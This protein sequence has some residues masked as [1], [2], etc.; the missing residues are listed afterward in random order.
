MKSYFTKNSVLSVLLSVALLLTGCSDV[1]GTKESSDVKEVTLLYTN[2]VHAQVE[3]MAATWEDDQPMMGGL[4]YYSSYINKIRAEEKNVAYLDAGDIITG[5]SISTITEGEAAIDLFNYLDV[6]ASVYGNHEF[7]HG[8]ERADS[9]MD[10][11]NFPLLAANVFHKDTGEQFGDPY[12]I[13]DING[14]KVGV[15]GILGK[16]AA[17]DTIFKLIIENLEFREQA[18][19]VQQY[20]DEIEDQVDLIVLLGHQGQ[21]AKQGLKVDSVDVEDKF[22]KDVEVANEVDGI[23]VLISGHAHL[24]IE[25][26]YVADSGTLIVSTRGLGVQVGYLNLEIQDGDIVNHKGH[27]ED[28][29]ADEIEPDPAVQERIDY[30]NQKMADL[31]NEEISYASQQLTRTYEEDSILG[32]LSADAMRAVTGADVAL[33]H[34]GGLRTDVEAGPLTVG[35]AISVL[36]FPNSVYTMT[37]TGEHLLEALEQSAGMNY[38]ILSPSGAE[39][40][41]DLSAEVGSRIVEATVNGKEIDPAAEYVVAL[42]AFVAL[43]GDDFTAFTKG[44]NV[45]S[46]DYTGADALISHLKTLDDTSANVEDRV[47][48]VNN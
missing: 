2:D 40:T 34:P 5:P 8:V 27:L 29:Y 18:P 35:E 33:Q 30:W 1:A 6:D 15:I 25:E 31:T 32:N 19:I 22:A 17:E 12:T 41:I 20:V 26:P 11:A 47:K 13:L 23:D 37:L 3:P 48:F 43:G 24:P 4:A 7:D 16:R 44:T 38:G 45:E 46:T 28:I 10:Q 9:F 14:I 36:P 21:A 39:M 42:D